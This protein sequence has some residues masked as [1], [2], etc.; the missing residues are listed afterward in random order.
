MRGFLMLLAAGTCLLLVLSGW[1][2]CA[3]QASSEGGL[4]SIKVS[5]NNSLSRPVLE[6]SRSTFGGGFTKITVLRNS[7]TGTAMKESYLYGDSLNR[8]AAIGVNGNGTEMEVESTFDGM[9][10]LGVYKESS[11]NATP[12]ETPAF[13][14]SE[15][16]SGSFKI[17]ER[18]DDYGSSV[19]SERSVSGTGF[20][21]VNKKVGDEQ[22]IHESGTGSYQSEE[23]IETYTNYIAKE[24]SLAHQPTSFAVGGDFSTNL[25]LKWNEGVSSKRAGESYIGEEYSGVSHLDK[26]TVALG[27]NEMKTEAEFSGTARYRVVSDDDIDMDEQYEGDYSLQRN[28]QLN[29]A[30]GYGQPHLNV[31]KEGTLVDEDE[32]T[33]AKYVI[34]IENDGDRTLEPVLVRDLFPPGS[35]FFSSNLRPTLTSGGANW[36]LTHI[37]PGQKIPIELVLDVTNFRSDELVNRV[38]AFGGDDDEWVY[39]A[40]FSA[41]EIDWLSCCSAEGVSVVKTGVADEV[42]PNHVLY[43]LGIQNLGDATLVATVTD[44]LPDGMRLIDSTPTFAAY[45]D[46]VVT[47]NLIDLGPGEEKTIVY[48]T[49]TLWSGKFVNLVEV[50]PRSVDGPSLRPVYAKSVVE[51]EEF[52]GE[53][54]RPGWQPP[55]WFG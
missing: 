11:P 23:R 20:V 41:V 16:Y 46:G 4:S 15:D 48:E 54:P 8:E 47:W 51:V 31:E 21:A 42:A 27:L 3:D 36:S 40:N 45:E 18:V 34:T 32:R 43:S 7:A 29:E 37:S 52:E 10:S 50:D 13:A 25:S 24:V 28:V 19:V 30:S 9:A 22:K 55:D 33:L 2:G 6:I 17:S 49:E 39:A 35:S 12:Q 14:A 1:G 38:E 5:E 44:Q 53:R 26:T